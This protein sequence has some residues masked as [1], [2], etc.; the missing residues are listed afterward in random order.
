MRGSEPFAQ[1]R[2]M[3]KMAHAE[4]GSRCLTI[5]CMQALEQRCASAAEDF[6]AAHIAETLWG[7]GTLRHAPSLDTVA[8]LLCSISQ[9]EVSA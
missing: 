7:F 5:C 9:T 1:P 2:Q 6:K 3:Q 8:Q 4:P